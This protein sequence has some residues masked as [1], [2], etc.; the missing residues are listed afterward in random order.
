MAPTEEDDDISMLF[1]GD[2]DML[3][4]YSPLQPAVRHVDDEDK[5]GF[6]LHACEHRWHRTCLESTER[7]AGRSMR[8]DS[9]GRVWVR[10]ETCRKDGW[11]WPRE[12]S[13][14]E[15]EVERL[16]EAN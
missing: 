5:K 16:C 14:S 4:I 8:K 10:C 9:Q 13:S 15:G 2:K 12:R 6:E 3:S 11:V 1:Q 7:C